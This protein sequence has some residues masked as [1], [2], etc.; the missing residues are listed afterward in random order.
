[1]GLDYLLDSYGRP[2]YHIGDNEDERRERNDDAPIDRCECRDI[3]EIASEIHNEYLSEKDDQDNKE[4]TRTEMLRP[5]GRIPHRVNQVTDKASSASEIL[6]VEEIP[7][8]HH[9]EEREE[10][11]QFIGAHVGLALAHV[12]ESDEK[13]LDKVPTEQGFHAGA[14]CDVTVP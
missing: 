10:H 4:E 3:E 5:V 1:M 14:G 6:G 12:G 9:H 11:R 7:E 8:L 2:S 13:L